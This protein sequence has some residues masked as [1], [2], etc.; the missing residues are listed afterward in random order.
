MPSGRTGSSPQ[1]DGFIRPVLRRRRQCQRLDARLG[2]ERFQT[3]FPHR[4]DGLLG[5]DTGPSRL[6]L[7]HLVHRGE[8][9]N[10]RSDTPGLDPRSEAHRGGNGQVAAKAM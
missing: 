10:G 1:A 4:L 5:A 3:G 9:V 8:T 6:G 7:L 2:N